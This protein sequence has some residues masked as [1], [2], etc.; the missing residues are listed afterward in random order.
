MTVT[1]SFI[2]QSELKKEITA[3]NSIEDVEKIRFQN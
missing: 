3:A 1:E 2:H